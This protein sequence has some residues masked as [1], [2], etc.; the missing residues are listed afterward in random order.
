[1]RAKTAAETGGQSQER[2]EGGIIKGQRIGAGANLGSCSSRK[3]GGKRRR[4]LL[5][6][7]LLPTGTA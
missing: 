4:H 7:L 3:P 6:L 1:M 2:R 5:L